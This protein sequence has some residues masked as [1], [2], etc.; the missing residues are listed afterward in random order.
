MLLSI[1]GNT[2]N[3][4]TMDIVAILNILSSTRS[5]PPNILGTLVLL[6]EIDILFIFGIYESHNQITLS[7]LLPLFFKENLAID[8]SRS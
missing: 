4:V 6:C 7:I 2:K 5:T 8:A 1:P 3:V